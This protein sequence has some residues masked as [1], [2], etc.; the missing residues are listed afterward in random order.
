MTGG[1]PSANPLFLR[2]EDLRQ[3]LEL[4]F[5]AS[6]D[7]ADDADAVL[8]RAGL[9]RAHHRAIYFIGRNP[10]ITLTGLLGILRV[11]K[12]SLSRVLGDLVQGGF[13]VQREGRGDRRRRPLELTEKGRAIERDLWQAQS[14]RMV[15]GYRHAGAEAVQGFRTV[16]A[17]LIDAADARTEAEGGAESRPEAAAPARAQGGRR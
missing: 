5:L 4:L 8:A 13:V 9:G 3:G 11:T 2:E 14:A 10:Q 1:R 15:R 17:G 12:Q 7:L 16:L 6:R